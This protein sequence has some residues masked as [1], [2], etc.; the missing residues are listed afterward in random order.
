MFEPPAQGLRDRRKSM[1]LGDA[2]TPG[3]RAGG[4]FY[5]IVDNNT[6]LHGRMLQSRLCPNATL[7]ET[8]FVRTDRNDIVADRETGRII[9]EHCASGVPCC[10]YRRFQKER[11]CEHASKA[12][13][14]VE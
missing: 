3:A 2:D 13:C 4:G 12:F 10:D 8:V 7:R 11:L 1:V 5:A 9:Q 14:A 6:H